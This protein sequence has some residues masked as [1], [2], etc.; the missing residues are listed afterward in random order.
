MDTRYRIIETMRSKLSQS[1]LSRKM[2]SVYMVGSVCSGAFRAK[3][4]DVDIL[5]LLNSPTTLE[6]VD[7]AILQVRNILGYSIDG[8]EIHYK[9]LSY[10]ELVDMASYDGFRYFELNENYCTLMGEAFP[11]L[12][13]TLSVE[14]YTNAIT[15]Q[16]TYSLLNNPATYPESLRKVRYRTHRNNE[17]LTQSNIT[18][19]CNTGDLYSCCMYYNKLFRSLVNI[20]TSDDLTMFLDE[21]FRMIR[22]EYLNKYKV[23]M[24]NRNS[25]MEMCDNFN[26]VISKALQ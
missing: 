23:Y 25:L 19:L 17:I 20:V 15:I 13:P 21:Y 3:Y 14:S 22:H 12:S 24:A 18:P 2:V 26:A 8:H 1:R 6:F 9:A 16:C 7:R 5:I 10:S 11:L 4:S